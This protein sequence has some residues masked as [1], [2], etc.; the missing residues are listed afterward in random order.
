MTTNRVGNMDKA[1]KSRI[2]I[3]IEYPDLTAASRRKIWR[4]F[5][6][7]SSQPN[8]FSETDLGELASLEVNGR[9]IKNILKTAQ[10]LASRKKMTLN[11]EFVDTVLAIEK[12][13]PEV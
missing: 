3:S 9:Q 2:H 10:L 6:K 8:D 4:N 13:R 1:F 5:L 12:G 7:A 11:R